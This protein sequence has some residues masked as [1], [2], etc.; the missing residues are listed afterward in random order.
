M[1]TKL[2]LTIKKSIIDIAKRKAKDKG[3]SLS[4]LFEEIFE[5]SGSNEIKTEQQRAAERLL[6][7]LSKS[8][9]IPTKDDK[10]LIKSHVKRKFA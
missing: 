9:S 2:T 7:R 5:E 8:T 4:R 6:Q 10:E 3:V 1:K